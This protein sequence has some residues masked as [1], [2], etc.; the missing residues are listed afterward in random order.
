MLFVGV[1]S[2]LGIGTLMV[3]SSSA[4]V[5]MHHY[6]DTL[7]FFKRQLLWVILGMSALLV[8]RNFDYRRLKRYSL[9]ILLVSTLLLCLVFVPSLS[10]E[11]NGARRWIAFGPISFQP[12][13]VTKTALIIFMAAKLSILKEKV[14]NFKR[15]L[16]PFVCIIGGIC[17]LI[18]F[19][20]HFGMSLLVFTVCIGMIFIVGARLLHIGYIA[21]GSF[22]LGSLLI[23]KFDYI[24]ERIT[25]FLNP[26]SDPFGSGYQIIQSFTALAGGGLFGV[27][28][29]GSHA[30]LF[31]LPYPHTDFIFAIIGEELGF[32]GAFVVIC[33]FVWLGIWGMKIAMEA[34]DMF[35]MLLAFGLSWSVIL[36][37]LLNMGMVTGIFPVTGLPLPFISFGGSNLLCTLFG[38]GVVLNISR[39]SRVRCG[40]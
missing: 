11:V 36:Q 33:L 22:L 38:I 31:Y 29:G 25:S 13:E 27:G 28:P 26:W 35:G 34:K 21:V 12:S 18:A 32:F 10:K 17:G 15:G 14:K 1:V 37:A 19:Q 3:Y 23:L 40:Y 6:Q 2:L 24:K 16:L 4:I 8:G 20:P 5:A 30:K 7:Y 39:R 9:P